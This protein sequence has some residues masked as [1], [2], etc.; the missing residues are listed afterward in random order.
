MLQLLHDNILER[1]WFPSHRMRGQMF[2]H[3]KDNFRKWLAT[4]PPA[5]TSIG[6]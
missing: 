1:A 6:S 4:A 5:Q 2:V 3:T